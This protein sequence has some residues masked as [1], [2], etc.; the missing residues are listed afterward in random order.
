LETKAI[1]LPGY[2]PKIPNH[3]TQITNNIQIP[4]TKTLQAFIWMSRFIFSVYNIHTLDA[5][6]R[7]LSFYSYIPHIY[8]LKT[9]SFLIFQ[10]TQMTD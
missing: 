5:A 10:I 7:S 9:L 6:I 2:D 8:F 3:N 4:T 1:Y